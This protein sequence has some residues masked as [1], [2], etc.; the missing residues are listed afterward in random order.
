MTNILSAGSQILSHWCKAQV[1]TCAPSTPFPN[2][3]PTHSF[4]CSILLFLL[5]LPFPNTAVS[6]QVLES[7]C[8][9]CGAHPLPYTGT[10]AVTCKRTHINNAHLETIHKIL[11]KNPYGLQKNGTYI[12]LLQF[13]GPW[14]WDVSSV[15]S[16]QL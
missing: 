11:G 1:M 13:R 3:P 5:N 8:G 12:F 9:M 2:P 6:F 7:S 14:G 15:L 4:F 16:S 10:L